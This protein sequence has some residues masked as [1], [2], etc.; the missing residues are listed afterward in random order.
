MDWHQFQFFWKERGST[1]IYI[2]KLDLKRFSVC[3]ALCYLQLDH[4]PQS[5]SNNLLLNH[6]QVATYLYIYKRRMIY[7]LLSYSGIAG[8]CDT[9]E[10]R[11]KS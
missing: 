8:L 4:K 2:K 6:I 7:K 10:G 1:F 9:S 5:T 11:P 3:K